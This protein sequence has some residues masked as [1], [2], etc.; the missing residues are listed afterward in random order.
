MKTNP[1]TRPMIAVDYNNEDEVL[2][3]SGEWIDLKPKRTIWD[4]DQNFNLET[5][6]IEV[7]ETG[8]YL[9][10]LKMTLTNVTNISKVELFIFKRLPDGDDQW[11]ELDTKFSGDIHDGVVKL[12]FATT[13]DFYNE[14]KY[15]FKI[16]LHKAD[17]NLD[18]EATIVGDDDYTAWDFSYLRELVIL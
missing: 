7:A 11:F 12:S 5:G 8:I 16:K 6:D 9:S 15:C 18:C 1:Q 17:E 10:T 4:N 13:F 2:N 3:V 14:E